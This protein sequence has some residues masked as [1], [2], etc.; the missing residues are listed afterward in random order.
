[1]SSLSLSAQS[2]G[3]VPVMHGLP[4]SPTSGGAEQG[5]LGLAM[6]MQ[7]QRVPLLP[8]PEGGPMLYMRQG[9]CGKGSKGGSSLDDV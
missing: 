2:S 6:K 3:A 9:M 1:M 5:G 8:T 7:Q 4:M